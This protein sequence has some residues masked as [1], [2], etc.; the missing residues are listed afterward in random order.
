MKSYP[1]PLLVFP[2][3]ILFVASAFVSIERASAQIP[4]SPQSEQNSIQLN[5]ENLNTVPEMQQSNAQNTE[6]TRGDLGRQMLDFFDGL[7]LSV[8][9][10]PCENIAHAIEK[11]CKEHQ[12]WID[13]LDYATLSIDDPTVAEIQSKAR[14]LGKTLSVCYSYDD[15]PKLLK[16]YADFGD[17]N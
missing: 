8:K 14:A 11:Y 4:H 10:V 6:T 13:D 5:R 7:S 15:I 1:V 17:I 16:R 2:S 3:L 12:T 9:D